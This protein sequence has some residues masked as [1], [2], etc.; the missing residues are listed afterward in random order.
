MPPAVRLRRQ[1]VRMPLPIPCRART[2]QL[3]RITSRSPGASGDVGIDVPVEIL[4][5]LAGKTSTIALTLQSASDNSVQL[6][7]RCDFSSLGSCSRHRVTATQERSDTL[8]RVTF[9]RT[10][11]PNQP[12]RIYINSDILGGSQ[13]G[14][15]LFGAHSARSVITVISQAMII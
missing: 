8:F 7:V 15:P 5:Q 13:A 11:A 10:L 2:E 9:D 1:R 6:S 12:G 4:R 14:L 3:L